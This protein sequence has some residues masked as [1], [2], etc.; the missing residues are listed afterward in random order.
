MNR[1]I[2][3]DSLLWKNHAK[4][5]RKCSDGDKMSGPRTYSNVGIWLDRYVN[6]LADQMPD[7]VYCNLPPCPTVE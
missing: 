4:G 1:K 6:T 3:L 7:T 5:L 2:N